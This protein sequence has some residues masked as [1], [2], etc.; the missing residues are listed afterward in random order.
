[1][2]EEPVARPTE[3][4][5]GEGSPPTPP[6]EPFAGIEDFEGKSP[7]D[8]ARDWTM[9]KK[10]LEAQTAVLE[11]LR[12]QSMGAPAHARDPGEKKE[13]PKEKPKYDELIYEGAEGVENAV[14]DIVTR[15]FGPAFLQAMTKSDEAVY[16]SVA[17]KLPD[18]EEYEPRIRELAREWGTQI[19]PQTV[20]ALY[21]VALGETTLENKRKA[22]QKSRS[23]PPTPK[24][25]EDGKKKLEEPAGAA[26]EFFR[27]SGMSL[28]EWDHYMGS[29]SLEMEVPT[30][31]SK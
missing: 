26:G 21:K 23:Q 18:F 19:T 17:R 7:E 15:N 13:S 30:G 11:N 6:A 2:P 8:I 16:M 3:G 22:A 5:G 9:M 14:V 31:R 28:E 29:E 25:P 1:M 20:E 24:G 4:E 27:S 12:N 10:T